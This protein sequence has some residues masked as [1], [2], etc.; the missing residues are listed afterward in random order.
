M[1]DHTSP[2]IAGAVE[3]ARSALVRTAIRFNITRDM[4][5]ASLMLGAALYRSFLRHFPLAPSLTS[6]Q[7]GPEALARAER[8]LEK[9][10]RPQDGPPIPRPSGT[11]DQR[12]TPPEVRMMWG[13]CDEA[14]GEVLLGMGEQS[15]KA[16]TLNLSWG[17][18][19]A[20]YMV[21]RAYRGNVDEMRR[22]RRKERYS[23]AFSVLLPLSALVG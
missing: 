9:V 18:H 13:T 4:D 21:S 11:S 5:D 8:Y 1:I 3:I 7:Y 22:I 16:L 2:E 19:K 17:L 12:R 15:R 20:L 23:T 6:Q 10:G 14:V